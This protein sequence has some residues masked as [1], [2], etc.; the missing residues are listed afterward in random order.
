MNASTGLYLG[1]R[2]IYNFLHLTLQEFL[3][4]WYFS[5]L[6]PNEQKF[7]FICITKLTE[8]KSVRKRSYQ[9][10]LDVMWTFV[11]GLTGFKHVGWMLVN[12]ANS[13]ILYN[14]QFIIRCL[15]EIQNPE[16]IQ[17]ACDHLLHFKVHPITLLDC[18]I[19]GYC[20]AVSGCSW[21]FNTVLYEAVMGD[22]AVEMLGN[23]LKSASEISGSICK[24]NLAS[25]NCTRKTIIDLC[26]SLPFKVLGQIN[27]INLYGN[28]L[29]KSAF[30]QLSNLVPHLINLKHISLAGNPGGD[31]A[32][33][34]LSQKLT[35][36]V[37]L[38]INKLTLGLG[39]IQALSLLLKSTQN[40]KELK[41]GDPYMSE[42]CV[43]L[44]VEV[45]FSPSSL[46]K[47]FFK[48]IKWTS[49]NIDNFTLLE[50]N[51]NIMVLIFDFYHQDFEDNALSLNPV[52][53]AVAKALHKNSTLY[54]LGVPACEHNNPEDNSFDLKHEN[55]VALSE[56]LKV[57]KTLKHLD[58]FIYLTY[59]DIQVLLGALQENHTLEQ[60][61]L[62]NGCIRIS[63]S[64]VYDD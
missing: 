9:S 50:N 10:P 22:E 37:S 13:D 57:N 51:K 11:A 32:M 40:L 63:K 33:V 6:P 17:A 56:M 30:D 27:D 29:D 38:N 48:S 28:N 25:S 14:H 34:K 21:G 45:V 47:I 15:Y 52:I 2:K 62:C 23:G 5:Q 4:A 24:F 54:H 44:I 42:E 49:N 35:Q 64:F 41:I 8:K 20:I 12:R 39:D 59:R 43:S 19:A 55:V 53:P 7:K 60:L 61:H 16:E 58:I 36:L 31:G 1:T 46:E 26:N 3:A 18:Y